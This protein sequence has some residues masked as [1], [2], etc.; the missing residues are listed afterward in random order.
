[1]R[2]FSP[3]D[4]RPALRWSFT[5]SRPFIGEVTDAFL[6]SDGQLH[7]DHPAGLLNKREE[8]DGQ[9]R[10]RHSPSHAVRPS[11]PIK[12]ETHPQ[13]AFEELLIVAAN[14]SQNL[15]ELQHAL[16]VVQVSY[17][18][19]RLLDQLPKSFGLRRR[20][21]WGKFWFLDQ[22]YQKCNN[23][24]FLTIRSNRELNSPYRSTVRETV[25]LT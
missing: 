25:N 4:L 2:A 1:M 15:Q 17:L 6:W 9:N 22:H 20:K 7:L 12:A 23:R 10:R 21:F 18:L 3:G 5:Y 19:K 13:R 8:W 16:L 24:V 14:R 11:E